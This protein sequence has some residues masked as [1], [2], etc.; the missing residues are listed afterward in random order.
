MWRLHSG[1][2]ALAGWVINEHEVLVYLADLDYTQ[3][4]KEFNSPL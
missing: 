2:S 4:E 1:T 3:T